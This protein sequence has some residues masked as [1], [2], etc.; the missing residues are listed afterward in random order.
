MK[1]LIVLVIACLLV[2]AAMGAVKTDD[3][4]THGIQEHL[5]AAWEA[6][7]EVVLP[8]GRH[9]IT[10]PLRAKCSIRGV[11]DCVLVWNGDKTDTPMLT[12]TGTPAQSYWPNV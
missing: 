5:D 1:R 2:V 10:E 6:R 12:V 4:L 7:D 3:T 11:G 8:P 9:R